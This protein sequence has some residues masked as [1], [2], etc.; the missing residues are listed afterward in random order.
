MPIP[1]KPRA[2]LRGGSLG[3]PGA[4]VA[5]CPRF[6]D[7]AGVALHPGTAPSRFARGTARAL[8][9]ARA[10]GHT[11]GPLARAR[12]R[13]RPRPSARPSPGRPG[14][15]AGPSDI[16]VRRVGP[17]A[18][19]T[20]H[21]LAANRRSRSYAAVVVPVTVK[22]PTA[23]RAICAHALQKLAVRPIATV[24]VNW[25]DLANDMRLVVA[26]CALFVA[27]HQS[28]VARAST[29]RS[30]ALHGYTAGLA[31]AALGFTLS[32]YAQATTTDAAWSLQWA[33]LQMAFGLALAP[34]ALGAVWAL[35]DVPVS[36]RMRAVQ[37][38]AASLVLLPWLGA[39]V[40]TRDVHAFRDLLGSTFYTPR[41]APA[42]A[43]ALVAYVI[44]IAVA[45]ARAAQRAG[46]HGPSDAIR[47]LAASRTLAPLLGA[48]AT[49][50]LAMQAGFVRSVRVL[51][52]ALVVAVLVLNYLLTRRS[53]DLHADLERS[54]AA[55]TEE[56]A[57]A[58]ANVRR[59]VDG[60]PDSVLLYADARIEFVNRAAV[61]YFGY[62]PDEL[63]GRHVLDL[64][65]PADAGDARA[66]LLETPDDRQQTSACE[67][68]FVHR[69]GRTLVGEVA[70]LPFILDGRRGV[71]A[72]IRDVAERTELQR[73][74]IAA[75]R[76][77]SVGTLAAGVAHEINNPLTYVIGNVA[78]A[79][80]E[81]R[82]AL[83]GDEEAAHDLADMLAE[84]HE[85]AERIRQIVRDLKAF[86]RADD[87]AT[88]AVSV[89]AV[90]AQAANL[91]RNEIRHRAR[92]AI[93]LGEVPHVLANEG[94]LVQVLLNLLVNAA[95][96]FDDI[97]RTDGDGDGDRTRDCIIEVTATSLGSHVE[98]AVADTGPGIPD[99][100]A[101]RLFDPF[102]TTKPVG[103]G[104]GLGLSI[105][106]GIVTSFGGHLSLTNRPEG[107]AIAR[108]VLPAATGAPAARPTPPR[109]RRATGQPRRRI[110]VVD[111]EPAVGSALCRM[112]RG[113]EVIAVDRGD[114]AIELA[115]RRTFDLI[116]VDV[117]MP[118]IS[119]IDVYE[120]LRAIDVDVAARIVFM[121]GGAFTPSAREA[122]A[123]LPNP[124][125]DKPIEP[126]RLSALLL[127]WPD[128]PSQDHA[129][130]G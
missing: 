75:D 19:A 79:R 122:L 105:C 126:D 47:R 120:A 20:A 12:R 112:L 7:F 58:L 91:A 57:A 108:I 77:A 42:A 83:D 4:F 31:A 92:L 117:M 45:V 33:R 55:R 89:A 104:T 123:A 59:I 9:G 128:D 50:D 115:A 62:E 52:F 8:S 76:L 69:S 16:P 43:V 54:V 14:S 84:A 24:P 18:G 97:D 65:A 78:T 60:L 127:R 41:V 10:Q 30:A 88:H 27:L 71:L 13:T 72:I 63:L 66:V 22:S 44:A 34:I 39:P 49:N 51:E 98:I 73:Q 107:G 38:G 29:G 130:R 129:D 87:N 85:G 111:D 23:A 124:K 37:V 25:V 96:S 46:A 26:G 99:D 56:L 32:R 67:M 1:L 116:L 93:N 100:I 68:R 121:T 102:F 86:S 6:H 64:V 53:A 110:L 40:M 118:S 70:C 74:L 90:A 101:D 28:W 81:L 15:L 119:G 17:A 36:R 125:L 61:D 11:R 48:A 5:P 103:V 21:R 94:R 106:H 113:H 35:A 95:Q 3:P 2:A 114:A 82:R 80:D 109:A